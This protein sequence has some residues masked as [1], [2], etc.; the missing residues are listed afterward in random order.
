MTPL[1]S[2]GFVF[3]FS[4][5]YFWLGGGTQEA[6]FPKQYDALRASSWR[7]KALE[8]SHHK[9]FDFILFMMRLFAEKEHIM[10][11]GLGLVKIGFGKDICQG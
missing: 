9:L 3:K 6:L 5:S 2:I 4:F 1:E 7:E 8:K 10:K 11:R